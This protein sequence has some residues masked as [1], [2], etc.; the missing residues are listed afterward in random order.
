LKREQEK[1]ERTMSTNETTVTET[2]ETAVI[3]APV[4]EAPV[5]EAPAK[6]PETAT[7]TATAT[8]TD[9]F[10]QHVKMVMKKAKKFPTAMDIVAG[11][12]KAN[13][14]KSGG[15]VFQ[16]VRKAIN[17]GLV[18]EEITDLVK[19]FHYSTP[20]R[21]NKRD[22]LGR[23]AR[24]R[25]ERGLLIKDAKTGKYHVCLKTTKDIDDKLAKEI[26]NF[27]LSKNKPSW[28]QVSDEFGLEF[29]NGT[30]ALNAFLRVKRAMAAAKKG[31]TVTKAKE[32]TAVMATSAK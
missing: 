24:R 20:L 11:L 2:P 26:Y 32:N 15:S 30:V 8:A 4:V 17:E 10:L 29:A 5:V 12:I 3:E 1:G 22:S 28:R 14:V 31:K 6:A 13:L 16:R 7:A 25:L 19:K 21:S 18:A 27:R 23:A 9:T